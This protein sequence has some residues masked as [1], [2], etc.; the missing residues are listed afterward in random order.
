MAKSLMMLFVTFLFTASAYSAPVTGSWVK[1]DMD[2]R[3]ETRDPEDGPEPISKIDRVNLLPVATPSPRDLQC[4]PS[5][6]CTFDLFYFKGITF[7]LNDSSRKNILFISGGPGQFVAELQA[8]NMALGA[9]DGTGRQIVDGKVI[10]E[11]NGKHNIVYFHLRGAGRSIIDGN[12]KFDQFLRAK[13][14]VE[15]IERLRKEVLGDKPWDAIYAHSWG[16]VV[17]QL[18]AKKYGEPDIAS[19]RPESR[20]KSL[21]LS[22]PIVR[23]TSST[24]KA[25]I[26]QTVS[27]LEKIFKFYR[28]VGNCVISD[29]KYLKGRITDF[30]EPFSPV[31]S[32]GKDLE[33]T[34]NLCFVSDSRV[35]DITRELRRILTDLEPDYGSVDFVKDHF[36]SLQKDRNFPASLKKYPRELYEAIRRVQMI[37][38]PERDGLVFTQDTKNMVD[39]AMI[40]GYYLTPGVSGNLQALCDSGGKFLTGAAAIPGIKT[41]YCDRLIKA[42][43]QLLAPNDGLESERARYVFGAYD[44]AARWL[45]RLLNK[46]C[47]TGEDL[48]KF[49]NAALGPTDRK[50]LARNT[51]KKI[52]IDTSGDLFCGWDPGGSNAHNVPTLIL[53]GTDDAI[54]AGCQA[55]D[56]YNRGLTGEKVL[57]EFPGMGHAMSVADTRA[58]AGAMPS[59]QTQTFADLIEKWV[60]M[61]SPQQSTFIANVQSEL[62]TLKAQERQPTQ[63]LIACRQ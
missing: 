47:F 43:A 44:G 29:E 45:S 24:L 21:I 53:A 31:A 23:R 2:P 59:A 12:N 28:P 3:A 39:L 63:G 6:P 11:P 25:R 35:G 1:K 49:A 42:K 32:A 37:G 60:T 19:G 16:T 20:V 61:G 38:A 34:D 33:K 56:F 50:K 7:K 30:D 13:Y 55:E 62:K 46:D 18:Y 5:S 41:E 8:G 10:P 4:N 48:R 51:A 57:L 14:V 27:N 22:A 52:G 40:I 54:I 15:D 36:D 58:A 17:A 9:L 26:K